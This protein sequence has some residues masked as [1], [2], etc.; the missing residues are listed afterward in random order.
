MPNLPLPDDYWAAQPAAV[1]VLRFLSQPDRTTTAKQLASAGYCIDM[2]CMVDQEMLPGDVFLVRQNNGFTWVPAADQPNIPSMP[3]ADMPGL[4][5]YDP[6]HPPPGS[7]HVPFNPDDYAHGPVAP[8]VPAPVVQLKPQVGEKFS[9]TGIGDVY[10]P[11]IGL[12]ENLIAEGQVIEQGG[13][14]YRAHVNWTARIP[15]YFTK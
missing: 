4:K 13:E 7:I 6:L 1:R 8:D 9:I 5:P 2:A 12:D 10:L 15:V 14:S 11:G 3:F